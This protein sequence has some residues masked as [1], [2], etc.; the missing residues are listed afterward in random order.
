MKANIVCNL[1]GVKPVNLRR[2]AGSTTSSKSLTSTAARSLQCPLVNRAGKRGGSFVVRQNDGWTTD[3]DGADDWIN[4]WKAR[5]KAAKESPPTTPQANE[6]ADRFQEQCD[7]A[8]SFNYVFCHDFISSPSS[9]TAE[10]LKDRLA[11]V[12]VDL[13]VPDLRKENKDYYSLSS[14]LESLRSV[15]KGK[16]NKIR[17]VGSR[18]GAILACL[19]AEKYPDEVDNV[20]LLEPIFDLPSSM[21]KLVGGADNLATW[22]NAGNFS[23]G[24]VEVP[25][26]MVEDAAEYPGFPFVRCQAYVVSPQEADDIDE[27]IALQWVRGASIHMRESGATQELVAERRLLE[28]NV[29][30]GLPGVMNMVATK[31]MTWN[32]LNLGTV[33]FAGSSMEKMTRETYLKNHALD[34]SHNWEVLDNFENWDKEEKDP[35]TSNEDANQN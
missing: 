29:G 31:M 24:G 17:L 26:G 12:G 34:H 19:Y 32:D 5:S 23:F 10:Y 25:Y 14:G 18:L 21:E 8:K 33:S 7:R 3:T 20:F 11:A 28:M 2:N 13:A 4:K 35:P 27:D 30:S 16:E 1:A 9:F 6:D 22:Q 15:L